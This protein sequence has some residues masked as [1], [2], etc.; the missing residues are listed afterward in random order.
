M[1]IQRYLALLLLLVISGAAGLGDPASGEKGTGK[2]PGGN[3][4]RSLTPK[5]PQLVGEN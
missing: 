5:K 4:A 2:A 1:L 3:E